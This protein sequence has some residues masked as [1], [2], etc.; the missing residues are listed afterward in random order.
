MAYQSVDL[1]LVDQE[2]LNSYSNMI[3]GLA[4]YLG[5]GYEIVLALLENYEHSV[6]NIIN[7]SHTGRKIGA[8]ITDLALNMLE[9]I[10]KYGQGLYHVFQHEQKRRTSEINDDRNPRGKR[11][12]IGLLCMNLYMNTSLNDFVKTLTPQ[13]LRLLGQPAMENFADN[14]DEADR[15]DAPAK[16]RE[17]VMN[18]SSIAPS[19]KKQN[20]RHGIGRL[21][22]L[23]YQ[24]RG[25]QSRQPAGYFQEYR[26][27]ASAQQA[28]PR[29]KTG[30]EAKTKH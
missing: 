15:I 23:Q 4:C 18:D 14:S 30:T 5:E 19:N 21:R 7:G 24:G 27:H 26:L 28:E 8:P 20:D 2:I 10:R 22:D 12:I 11:K 29:M 1:T 17:R 25:H 6:I 3:E 9:K 16:I 13:T